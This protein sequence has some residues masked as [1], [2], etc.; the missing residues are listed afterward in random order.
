MT[1]FGPEDS[2]VAQDRI[3]RLAAVH[4]NPPQLA[5]IEIFGLVFERD[6]IFGVHLVYV[7]EMHFL[8]D[9]ISSEARRE[10][11]DDHTKRPANF[12]CFAIAWINLAF[13]LTLAYAL[14]LTCC[15]EHHMKGIWIAHPLYAAYATKLGTALG[16]G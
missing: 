6:G 1:V 9:E 8:R 16:S 11:F 5:C 3:S 10:E 4:V 12:Q 15:S 7:A 2:G 14:S 13:V